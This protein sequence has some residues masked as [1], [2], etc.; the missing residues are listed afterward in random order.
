M[1][2]NQQ[3]QQAFDRRINKMKGDG[4]FLPAT[5]AL[6]GTDRYLIVSYGGTGAKALFGVKQKFETI[7]SSADIN[8][9]IRFLAIDTDIATQR[10]TITEKL[11]DGTETQVETDR[12]TD[13]QFYQL[14]GG[15]ARNIFSTATLPSSVRSWINPDLERDVKTNNTLL[16]GTGAS[17]IRQIGRL[18]LFPTIAISEL[19]KRISTLVGELT[20]NT[21]YKLRV[22]VLTGIAGGTGSGTVIDL[23][24]LIRD[25]VQNY[26]TDEQRYQF[27]GFVL[28]P[29]TGSA[30][31]QS[32]ITHG[33]RNGYAA[34]KEINHFMTLTQRGDSYSFTYEDGTTVTS[35]RE[36][37][38]NCYL[39]DG[40]SGDVKYKEPMKQAVSVLAE[41][42]LDMITANQ[43]QDATGDV[44]QAVDSFMNDAATFTASMIA[45]K[46][47]N[48]AV[49]DA[50]YIYCA[51]GHSEFAMPSNEIKAYVAKKMFDKIYELF[52]KCGNVEEDDVRD[53]V[54]NVITRGVDTANQTLRNMNAEIQRIFCDLASRKAGPFYAINLL[55]DVPDEV[56][57]I[58]RT[59]KLFRRPKVSD[60]SLNYI[61]ASARKLN[62]E[63]FNVFT[64][65]MEALKQLMGDQYGLVVQGGINGNVYS[66]MPQNLNDLSK[67]ESVI[68]YLDDLISKENLRKMT[69]ALL[70]ELI[71]NHDN[72]VAIVESD[73][74]TGNK[75]SDAMRKF[76]N[77]NLDKMINSTMEDFLIKYFSGNPGAHYD[78]DNHEATA[79][80]LRKAASAI[81]EYMLGTGGRAQPMV[82]ITPNGLTAD[83]LNGHTYLM[84]PK[85]APNLCKELRAIASMRST[86]DNKVDVFTSFA[87]DVVSCY[88]QYTSI[89]AFKLQW[90][91]VAE[92]HYEK[93][94]QTQA[95]R[96]THMSETV[97][98][99][100]WLNFP[101]LLPRSVWPLLPNDFH[102]AREAALA[103]RA[104]Q[105]FDSGKKLGLM[106]PEI[107]PTI[108]GYYRYTAKLLPAEFRPDD[109]LY[110]EL[111]T[112][113]EGADKRDKLAAIDA[114]AQACANELFK[115]LP[116]WTAEAAQDIRNALENA[117]V[118][119]TATKLHFSQT[120]L[121][122][123]PG[124]PKPENWD[125]A[126]AA[127]LLRKLPETMNELD[128]SVIVLQKLTDM[129]NRQLQA[130]LLIK[131]FA[132]YINTGMFRFNESTSSW[133]YTAA[134]G[135]NTELV[136][137]DNDLQSITELYQM[138][139]AYRNKADT[140]NADLLEQFQAIAPVDSIPREE[141]KARQDTFR[142]SAKE[143]AEKLI[144]WINTD[145]TKPY[146]AIAKTMGMNLR[147][148]KAFYKDLLSEAQFMAAMGYIP[149]VTAAPEVEEE[150]EPDTI[151]Y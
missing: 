21:P 138:F 49:R 141:K 64:V 13:E 150:D 125:D 75:A 100:R 80:D 57:R 113:V 93:E 47:V 22:F 29:P 6:S 110:R 132:Q 31:S 10:Q 60:D 107:M 117:G 41:S 50:D 139:A 129:V 4:F 69:D 73:Q 26:L 28:L 97:G 27:C 68:T 131:Q 71:D 137:L 106:I 23:T 82:D 36:I 46:S 104:D 135:L 17:G 122:C 102:N 99:K 149:V 25:A 63:T 103:E 3:Q 83:D 11:P 87:S 33:N 45:G 127:N 35:K 133:E 121:T 32:A 51:L 55:R 145:P 44:V 39:L 40:V 38:N 88:R 124:E 120:I 98:G 12:L 77:V 56:E 112:L 84:V 78:P 109:N 86:A 111:D 118:A 20:D 94:I 130:R 95:A 92:E 151:L 19:R 18:T 72:W 66:F 42:L 142:A 62:N 67:S 1:A 74:T 123:G 134:N 2:L 65:A 7:L 48:H 89:P 90:T 70:R 79:E 119:F 116:E 108:A 59:A 54:R 85:T 37:F 91:Q 58:R 101:N 114:A 15:A 105:L 147:A 140:V 136:Y 52:Q 128:G 143:L 9:R 5:R 148:I 76:W 144:T 34:L 96:G 126:I 16:N 81:Y 30:T 61:D 8:E 53:F 115:K 24:Y 43:M 146:E 14:P